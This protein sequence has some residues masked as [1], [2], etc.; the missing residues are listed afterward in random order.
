MDLGLDPKFCK[1][2]AFWPDSS[3]GPA[4]GEEGAFPRKPTG[5]CELADAETVGLGSREAPRSVKPALCRA[6]GFGGAR[7]IPS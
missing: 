3:Q 5:L 6:A 4:H 7:V 1:K 2:Q